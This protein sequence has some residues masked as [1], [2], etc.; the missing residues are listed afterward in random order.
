MA[1]PPIPLLVLGPGP[2]GQAVTGLLASD[3]RF[4]PRLTGRDDDLLARAAAA[5]LPTVTLAGLDDRTALAVLVAQSRAVILTDT[6]LAAAE[7]AAIAAERGCHYLDT[8]ENP[9]SA[10]AVA[11]CAQRLSAPTCFA[12][13]CGL[14]PG[15]VT[16]LAGEITDRADPQSEVTVFVG[17]LPRVRQNRLGYA[18][19]WDIEGLMAEY[20]QPCL[21]VEGGALVSL[22]PLTG[23]EQVAIGGT[24]YE[25]FTTAGSID[26][27]ARQQA[28]RL[29]GLVFKTLRYPGHLDYMQFLFDDLG[30]R[31]RIYRVKSLLMTALPQ[32]DRDRV[33]VAIRHRHG[34]DGTESWLRQEF[35]AP[36]AT[37]GT[38]AFAMASAAHVCAMAEL[39]LAGGI[40]R[41][42]LIGAGEIGPARLRASRFFAFLDSASAIT[43]PG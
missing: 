14:A 13:G 27:L 32:T 40:R 16:G 35:T 38:S 37:P 39:M 36:D 7:V 6:A 29:R 20:T 23:L 34:V 31:D 41:A 25:A 28:G 8:L 22:P 42:G 11:A 4:A 1:E 33:V 3:G 26:G 17:V 43:S 30:L 21:A 15:Y 24:D 5:G 2:L 18:N 10:A 9:A 19:I 12:P